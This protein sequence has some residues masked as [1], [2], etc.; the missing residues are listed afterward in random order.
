M[1][2]CHTAALFSAHRFIDI[3]QADYGAAGK[4]DLDF[5]RADCKSRHEQLSDSPRRLL[6]RFRYDP[7]WFDDPVP[8]PDL[9][10]FVRLVELCIPVSGLSA[11][12]RLGFSTLERA[13]LKAGWPRADVDHVI[14]GRRWSDLYRAYNDPEVLWLPEM[15]CF[16]AGWL[17][18]GDAS[19]FLD[20]LASVPNM[21]GEES[22]ADAL[23][24]AQA[25]LAAASERDLHLVII[26][27]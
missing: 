18:P 27:D 6:E 2:I 8:S 14:R 24:D 16:F 1:T 12:Q 10:A 21:N 3:L 26:L 20:R 4:L 9:W 13:L 22:L 5:M 7:E 17:S 11:S 19:G 25:M 15:D 23:S